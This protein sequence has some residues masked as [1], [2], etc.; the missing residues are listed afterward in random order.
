[1][2]IQNFTTKISLNSCLIY[3]IYIYTKLFTYITHI[4]NIYINITLLS[5]TFVVFKNLHIQKYSCKYN[6]QNVCMQVHAHLCKC[7]FSLPPTHTHT[8][9]HTHTHTVIL[10]LT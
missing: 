7:V 5:H 8:L 3:Y 9:A 2:R 4:H 10:I 6:F 1:M